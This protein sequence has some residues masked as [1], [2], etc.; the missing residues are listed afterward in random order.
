MKKVTALLIVLLIASVLLFAAGTAEQAQGPKVMKIAGTMSQAETDGEYQGTKEFARLVE[1]YTNGS[2]K[3]Q[4]YPSSQLGSF[5][6]FTEGVMMGTIEACV[7]GAS[8]MGTNDPFLYFLEMPYIF[9]D[10][11]HAR[12]LWETDNEA[13]AKIDESLAGLN[14]ISAGTLYRSPR[15]W[16]NNKRPVS[17]PK[18]NTGIKM[19]APNSPIS[20]SFASAMGA[21]PV[22]VAWAEVYTALSA[23]TVDGVENTVTELFNNNMHE[24]VKY[25]AETNHMVN[26]QNILVSKKW[27]D[28]LSASEQAAIKKAGQEATVWRAN[29]LSSEVKIAWEAFE[30][31]GVDIIWQADLDM[32][33]FAIAGQS[34]IDEYVGKGYFTEAYLDM[35]KGLGK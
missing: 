8:A 6:E 23:G 5:N 19:R 22:S 10:L 21:S 7:C 26:T 17:S 20:L 3:C 24:V 2:I 35:V 29:Q 11:N 4:I 34:V 18:D 25:C 13:K 28:S 33:A 12:N 27:F 1:L 15:V 14:M 31:R 9:K 30:K 16:C 32:D